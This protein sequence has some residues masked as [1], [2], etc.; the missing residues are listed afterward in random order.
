[1]SNMNISQNK[2]LLRIIGSV[3][4]R[5]RLKL[6]LRGLAVALSLGLLLVVSAAY[7]MDY[8]R[9]TPETVLIVR[10]IVYLVIALLLLKY[11]VSPLFRGVTDEKIALYLEEHEPSLQAALVS[12]VESHHTES[13]EVSGDFL[14]RMIEQAIAA[15]QQIGGGRRIETRNLQKASGVLASV[16]AAAALVVVWSPAFLRHALPFLMV[17]W[18]SEAAVSPY[19]VSVEPGDIRIARGADQLI[20][21]QLSGFD[22]SKIRLL[23]KSADS[24][25]WQALNMTTGAEL[26][27]YELFLFD[28]NQPMDYYVEADGVRSQNY[29]IEVVELPTVEQIGL[30]YHYPEYTGLKPLVIEDGGDISVLRGTE[31]TFTITPSIPVESGELVLENGERIPLSS[32]GAQLSAE[33]TITEDSYYRVELEAVY[34]EMV[35]ASPDYIIAALEDQPPNIV[36]S[37]P[38]RDS[39]VTKVEEPLFEIKAEDD[40]NVGQLELMLSV[41]GAPAQSINL[42][43]S[44]SQLK[45]V[46][47]EHILYLEDLNLQPGDLISYYARA[48]DSAILDQG[49]EAATDIFFLEIR[50]FERDFRAAEQQGGM[51]GDP[52][53]NE[54]TLSA[55][56][57]ELVVAVFKLIRDRETYLEDTFQENLQTLAHAQTRI[58][59]RVEAIIRR[60]GTRNIMQME[61]GYQIMA[62]ELPKAV[63]SMVAAEAA[64]N[65]SDPD[66]A[67]PDAQQALQHLQRAD[68]AFREVQV[69]QNSQSGSGQNS[70]DAEEDLANLFKLELDKLR[71]QYESV[72][73]ANQESSEQQ[74]DE[75]MQKL[76]ELARRQQQENE[77]QRRRASLPHSPTS[78]SGNQQRLA[79]QV[80]EL[81]RQLE[82]LTREQPKNP[83]LKD[84]QEQLEKAAESMR[85]ASNSESSQSASDRLNQGLEAMEKLEEARRLLD[86]SRSVQ[87]NRDVA[88]AQ[89][90]AERLAN[91]Q[92]E[93]TK[94][95]NNLEPDGEKRREQLQRLLDHKREMFK[96]TQ[97]LEK[98]LDRIARSAKQEQSDAADKLQEAANS[99]RSNELDN[100]IRQSWNIIQN[101]TP[102]YASEFEQGIT[103]DINELRQKLDRAAG[104]VGESREQQLARSLDQMQELVRDLEAMRERMQMQAQNPQQDPQQP[105]GQQDNQQASAD[106]QNTQQNSENP[107]AQQ[108]ATA[109]DQEGQQNQQAAANDQE[110]Q[111]QGNASQQGQNQSQQQ[112]SSDQQTAQT[113]EDSQQGQQEQQGDPPSQQAQNSEQSEQQSGQQ[114]QSNQQ[115]QNSNSPSQQGQP[116]QQGQQQAQ[117]DQPGQQGQQP[118]QQGQSGQQGQQPGQQPSQEGQPSQSAQMSPS[119]GGSQGGSMMP[120][121]GGWEADNRDNAFNPEDIQR[122]MQEFSEYRDD[123]EQLRRGLT[124]QNFSEAD[125]GAVLQKLR[126][127]EQRAI[128]EDPR[129]L[130]SVQTASIE[131][132]KELEFALRSELQDDT[133]NRLIL[134]GNEDIPEGFRELVEEYYRVLSRKD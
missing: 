23:M 105:G 17:P 20:S 77:R 78:G 47:G 62:E 72:Q 38:G 93:V 49:Q 132:L 116:G 103:S 119:A 36:I 69:S 24:E 130:V 96:D 123:L 46:T 12:A 118:G 98:E 66:K 63:D 52:G 61:E 32:A 2:D 50:P 11:V 14:K 3:R 55:Q 27:A 121:S 1:M 4:R 67:L 100:K 122:F 92:Q 124:A 107:S 84:M 68:A 91:R 22:T 86:K 106:Q 95:V 30:Q 6:L 71:N 42:H 58:R 80:E 73:R 56:Q 54:G 109:T 41:N 108:Q 33:L 131:A 117:S 127:L 126:T 21:A 37:K 29:H 8:F 102:E 43:Q 85:Q 81:Q 97:E 34:G 129:E 31:V 44:N 111:Q 10:A 60:L 110:G 51:S 94:D 18:G 65:A 35:K 25:A 112:E 74:V 57:R 133:D 28:L 19:S 87:L 114:G 113:G 45:Q 83:E 75:I 7:A 13:L 79:E 82:R 26:G 64:L 76:R 104:D 128:Y 9:F 40:L 120:R 101:R 48:R 5:W 16:L 90:R 15:C 70:G 89:Q 59:D 99:I 53:A 125:V 134:S 115:A 39:K 88:E